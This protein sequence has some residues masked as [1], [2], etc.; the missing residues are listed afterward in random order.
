M[1]RHSVRHFIPDG[2]A[3]VSNDK[4]HEESADNQIPSDGGQRGQTEM[5]NHR[6]IFE[7]VKGSFHHFSGL[8]GRRQAELDRLL[9]LMKLQ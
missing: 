6:R 2:D 1:E 8:S 9:I 3:T 4:R 5:C 7:K